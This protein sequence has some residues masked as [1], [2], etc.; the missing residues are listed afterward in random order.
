MSKVMP[1]PRFTDEDYKQA[2]KEMYA[3]VPQ[4]KRKNAQ[5]NLDPNREKPRSL[6]HI[7]DDEEEYITF[8]K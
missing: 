1:L 4:R 6:H 3:K 2:E 7:D 8:I 5:E